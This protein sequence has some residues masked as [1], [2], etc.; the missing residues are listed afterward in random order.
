MEGA[1]PNL[2]YMRLF[3][4]ICGLIEHPVSYGDI[5]AFMASTNNDTLE[6]ASSDQNDPGFCKSPHSLSIY[7][8]MPLFQIIFASR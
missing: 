5:V 4:H 2:S 6:E 7:N 1:F 3:V 8:V